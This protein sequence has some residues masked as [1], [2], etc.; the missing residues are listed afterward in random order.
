MN[1]PLD[2]APMAGQFEEGAIWWPR[3]GH[4]TEFLGVALAE[5]FAAHQNLARHMTAFLSSLE[6]VEGLLL[7]LK[8]IESGET[9]AS[10]PSVAELAPATRLL[11]A[12]WEAV[13]PGMRRVIFDRPD[14]PKG[15]SLSERLHV[16]VA[17]I[18]KSYSECGD[19]ENCDEGVTSAE[20]T[21]EPMAPAS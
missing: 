21:G 5:E 6:E 9:A 18:C 1:R 19:R 13:E 16:R 20:L 12:A 15:E 7:D 14:M 17:A 11:R 8:Y 4:H 3:G 2:L 10:R